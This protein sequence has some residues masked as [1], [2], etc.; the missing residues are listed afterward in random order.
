MNGLPRPPRLIEAL[1]ALLP[2]RVRPLA[3]Q[4]AGYV[5]VS[6]TALAVDVAVYWSLFKS[7]RIAAVAAAGGYLFG[8]LVHYMLSSRVVFASRLGARGVAAE[9]PVLAKFFAAGGAGMLVT[10]T[11]VGVLADILGMHALV[12]KLMAAGLSFV[13]V[14]TVLRAFVFNSPSVRNA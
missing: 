1:L 14:F 3:R 4:F 8:V 9:A 12:A 2:E 11:T 6:G 10:V 7:I 13:T 5:A